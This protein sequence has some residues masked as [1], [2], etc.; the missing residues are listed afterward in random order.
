[1]GIDLEQPSGEYHTEENR[2]PNVNV[3]M[4]DGGDEGHDRDGSNIITPSVA[5]NDKEN[6]GPNVN[7]RVSDG[8]NMGHTGEGINLNSCKSL[9][10][11]DGREFE[12]KEEAFSFYKEYAKSV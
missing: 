2:R 4:V 3:N 5:G 6:T 10:P 1:M 7:G 12:S 8:R 11:H 9:E